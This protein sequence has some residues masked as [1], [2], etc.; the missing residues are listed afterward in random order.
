MNSLAQPPQLAYASLTQTRVSINAHA[1]Q[2]GYAVAIRRT[3][4]IGNR[5]VGDVKAVYLDCYRSHLPSIRTRPRHRIS[6][7]SKTG[8]LFKTIVRRLKTGDWQVQVA[9]GEHNHEPFTHKAAHPQGRYLTEPNRQSVLSL[10][11]AGVKPSH[12]IALLRQKCRRHG[13]GSRHLQPTRFRT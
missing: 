11:R 2:E 12:I 10:T 8:C 1:Q 5:K 7:S 3:R 6:S 4:R 9:N 13:Y